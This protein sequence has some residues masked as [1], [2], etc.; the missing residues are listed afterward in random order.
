VGNEIRRH[1]F[2]TTAVE[3]SGYIH[4]LTIL[5]IGKAAVYKTRESMPQGQPAGKKEESG[6]L[7]VAL[8]MQ[9]SHQ[10]LCS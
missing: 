8:H 1:I 9:L 3:V 10:S 6:P 7:P 5:P 2:L 4:I